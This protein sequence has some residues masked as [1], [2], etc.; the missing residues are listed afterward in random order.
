MDP[1]R[2]FIRLVEVTHLTQGGDR[3]DRRRHR[4]DRT[5]LRLLPTLERRRPPAAVRVRVL[6]SAAA[7]AAAAAA[8]LNR[9]V[10][11]PP[12]LGGPRQGRESPHVVVYLWNVQK[13]KSL[14]GR[15]LSW[16]KE[17]SKFWNLPLTYFDYISAKCTTRAQ[18]YRHFPARSHRS[19]PW[20]CSSAPSR[21]GCRRWSWGGRTP[22]CCATFSSDSC[23]RRSRR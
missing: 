23:R 3:L 11:V 8:A 17:M 21:S 13:L 5:L 14:S 10:L 16:R 15:P 12:A 20:G 1:D 19:R 4:R 7:A 6:L 2:T 9:I 18:N 22:P